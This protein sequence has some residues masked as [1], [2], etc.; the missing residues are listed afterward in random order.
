M[1]QASESVPQP[2]GDL[3]QFGAQFLY[4]EEVP[5]EGTR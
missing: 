4:E 5:R 3:L 2:L 1:A